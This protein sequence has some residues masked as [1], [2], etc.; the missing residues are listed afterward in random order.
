MTDHSPTDIYRYTYQGPEIFAELDRHTT[1]ALA[2]LAARQSYAAALLSTRGTTT[3]RAQRHTEAA[4]FAAA[5]QA[6]AAA[7][8]AESCLGGTDEIAVQLTRLADLMEDDAALGP[9]TPQGRE[10]EDQALDVL[11]EAGPRGLTDP[12]FAAALA[13]AGLDVDRHTRQRFL[14]D[15]SR[16][17]TGLNAVQLTTPGQASVFVHAEHA[18]REN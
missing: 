15:W 6:L 3:E 4:A 13:G 9:T 1:G 18:A 7:T 16:Y 14:A 12:E 5:A 17:A 2:V 8:R 10:L 11:R